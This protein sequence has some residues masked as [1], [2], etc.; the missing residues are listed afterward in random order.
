MSLTQLNTF[1]KLVKIKKIKPNVLIL[2]EKYMKRRFGNFK[3][4]V[5]LNIQRQLFVT[6]IKKYFKMIN[7]GKDN[8]HLINITKLFNYI[9]YYGIDILY[10]LP[11]VY[12]VAVD[13]LHKIYIHN[14]LHN[15]I[16]DY[17]ILL[18]N[19][20]FTCNYY[21]RDGDLCDKKRFG[22][23]YLCKMH[24]RCQYNKEITIRKTL[25]KSINNKY[26]INIIIGYDNICY[27]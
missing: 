11:K 12:D 22:E 2:K 21:K 17:S 15:N 7:K 5:L 14:K 19:L 3:R 16:S 27:V 8:K 18:K 9:I 25:K 4:I 23:F 13:K 10:N 24:M 20:H 26:L 6:T 1:S